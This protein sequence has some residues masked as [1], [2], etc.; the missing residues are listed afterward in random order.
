VRRR[1]GEPPCTGRSRGFLSGI[2]RR[3]PEAGSSAGR[4]VPEGRR[5]A[6]G[7]RDVGPEPDPRAHGRSGGRRRPGRTAGAVLFG[8]GGGRSGGGRPAR[9]DRSRLA[10]GTSTRRG[11][12]APYGTGAPKEL[13][14][15]L[16][17][18]EPRRPSVSALSPDTPAR[19][20]GSRMRDRRPPA[21]RCPAVPGLMS[22]A[23]AILMALE[24]SVLPSE[25]ITCRRGTAYC[26]WQPLIARAAR[27]GRQSRRRRATTW[28]RNSTTAPSCGYCCP[29]VRVCRASL[30]LGYK[31]DHKHSS[32]ECLLRQE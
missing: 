9:C 20:R 15:H 6:S 22:F 4:S 13:Q 30:D 3:L 21:Y 10:D 23:R 5:A 2:A 16:P 25:P 11:A 18:L 32:R 8:A 14:H 28:L 29:A 17:A 31:K 7:S 12:P 19:V 26:W 24:S 27:S 1:R